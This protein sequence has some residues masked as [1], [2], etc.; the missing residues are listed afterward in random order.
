MKLVIKC[1]LVI[2]YLDNKTHRLHTRKYYDVK[3]GSSFE[4]WPSKA[5]KL[6]DDINITIVAIYFQ[7][8]LLEQMGGG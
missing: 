3:Y 4:E 2:K 1:P 6:I 5:R 7:F 8:D